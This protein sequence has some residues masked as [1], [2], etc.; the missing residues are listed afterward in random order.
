MAVLVVI[1][2][3]VLPDRGHHRRRL[4]AARRA[5]RHESAEAGAQDGELQE[6]EARREAKYRE[7]RDAELDFQTGKLSR[8][9]H[10]AID[11]AL[12]SEALDILDRLE[13][14]RGARGAPA[15][16]PASGDADGG[17]AD[18][19]EA[20]E[21]GLYAQGRLSRI[22]ALITNR[23]AKKIVQRLRLRSTIEPPPSGP[24]PLPTP[25]APERPES[26]PECSSTRKITI[27][28]RATWRIEK[29]VS[30]AVKST[31]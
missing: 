24:V 1:L 25:K 6:L 30:I 14:F 18:G 27:S 16:A 10:A 20:E 28:E 19:G 8:E 22:T 9:D 4:A 13:R 11:A 29:S 2:A 5:A 15:G 23:I 7:I 21:R 31:A 17:E 26:L 12:R 3:L